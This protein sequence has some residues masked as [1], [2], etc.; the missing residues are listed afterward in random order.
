MVWQGRGIISCLALVMYGY[1]MAT[2]I[3]DL[4]QA[5]SS[6]APMPENR[7]FA[8]P[9]THIIPSLRVAERYDSNVFFVPGT[10][11]EDYVTTVSPQLK[12]FHRNQWVEGTVGGGATAEAYVKNPGL[13]Y[14]AGNGTMSLNLDG[15]MN[16]FV[17]GLG[18][19]LYDTLIYTPQPLAF[20]APTSG[21]QIPPA[22]VQGIQAQRANSLSNAA[23]V[24]ASY[25]L[26]DFMG[27]TVT[28]LDQRIRFGNPIATPTGVTQGGFINTNFQTLTS[29]FDRKLSS[30]DTVFVG[31]QYQNGTFSDSDASSSQFSTQGAL[32]RWLRFITPGLKGT[33]E[34]GFAVISPGGRVELLGGASLEWKEQYTTVTVSYSRSI[35]PSFLFVSTP[36]LSQVVTGEVKRRI[37]DSL[38]L[39]VNGS[40]AFNESVPDSSLLRFQSYAVTPGVNYVI[41]K[42]F[43][44]TL[45]YT[46][47]Q[48][49]QTI[50]SE[51][52]PFDRDLVQ[53]SLIAEWK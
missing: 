30:A 1:G 3:P 4:A 18:L 41:S 7:L 23:K 6:T 29:G 2:L 14:L 9:D 45:S 36:L 38:T 37:T 20:A 16:R 53:L 31:H 48:Y 10:N 52:F 47:S 28:Y 32:I 21:S 27:M 26:S 46:H 13:N 19:R 39:S 44:A 40:Y 49:E 12:L 22:F 34:G 51:S 24:E 25:R 15:V 17:Q 43:T 42:I 35:A 8:E 11:L 33:G 5:Q 50:A